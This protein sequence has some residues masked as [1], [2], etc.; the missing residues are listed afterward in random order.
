MI[1]KN[2]WC[3]A[4]N[5][6]L[7]AGQQSQGRCRFR[8]MVKLIMRWNPTMLYNEDGEERRWFCMKGLVGLAKVTLSDHHEH[9]ENKSLSLICKISP[10]VFLILYDGSLSHGH[11]DD[12]VLIRSIASGLGA[13]S[14]VSPQ[15]LH[16]LASAS[17]LNLFTA[18]L[19]CVPKSVQ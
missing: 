18:S 11:H 5:D 13:T 2:G 6:R 3:R 1:S 15:F 9:G 7:Q 10:Q 8:Y 19:I 16:F 14:Q 4:P 17:A 12:A